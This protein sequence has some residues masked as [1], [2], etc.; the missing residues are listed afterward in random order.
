MEK[1]VTITL[2]DV[3]YEMPATEV[4]RTMKV[5]FDGIACST[6]PFGHMISAGDGN[7]NINKSKE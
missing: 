5:I 2:R 1:S 4:I 7:Y 3:N 6:Y